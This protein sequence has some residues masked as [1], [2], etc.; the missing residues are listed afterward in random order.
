MSIK[1]AFVLK[2]NINE[3]STKTFCGWDRVDCHVQIA[4][5]EKSLGAELVEW[6]QSYRH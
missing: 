2:S 3:Y 1:I 4:A 6:H 5:W